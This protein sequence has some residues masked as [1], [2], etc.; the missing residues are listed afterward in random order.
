MSQ[1]IIIE[2]EKL[3]Q[4]PYESF[5]ALKKRMNCD[6]AE[7]AMRGV[8]GDIRVLILV[9]EE[10]RLKENPALNEVATAM[11]EY[12]GNGW[13]LANYLVGTAALVCDDGE[14]MRGFTPEEFAVVAERFKAEGL[15]VE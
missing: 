15:E 3:V 8:I 6:M 1:V 14:D 7:V 5:G 13:W 2:D 9:D 12:L 11:S 4:V 10:G